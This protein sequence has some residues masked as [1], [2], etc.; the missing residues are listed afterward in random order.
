MRFNEKE[1]LKKRSCTAAT[2][3]D[4]KKTSS[5][6]RETGSTGREKD[7][8]E[9]VIHTAMRLSKSSFG[10]MLKGFW[11]CFSN[12]CCTLSLDF[13]G[14]SVINPKR[15]MKPGQGKREKRRVN[16]ISIAPYVPKFYLGNRGMV[17]SG[18][19]HQHDQISSQGTAELILCRFIWSVEGR[20]LMNTLSR[21]FSR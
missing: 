16:V 8:R 4:V 12:D 13:Q 6:E 2:T 1:A 5:N 11:K 19:S 17:E 18:Y 15:R 10:T 14:V 20:N 9:K 21:D 3:W 7:R